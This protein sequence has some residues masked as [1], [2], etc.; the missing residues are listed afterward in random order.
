MIPKAERLAASLAAFLIDDLK[1]RRKDWSLVAD[2]LAQQLRSAAAHDAM[3]GMFNP[4]AEFMA[5]RAAIASTM[6]QEKSQ[7]RS[8]LPGS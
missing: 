4:S 5:R 2:L 7:G 1:L 6:T 8:A 3:R